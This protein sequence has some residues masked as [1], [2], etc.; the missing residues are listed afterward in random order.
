MKNVDRNIN[1]RIREIA[2]KIFDGNITAMAKA[3]FISRTTIYS[4]IGEKEVSPGYDVLRKLVEMTTPQINLEWLITGQGEMLFE[5]PTKEYPTAVK[6]IP[7]YAVDFAAGFS[8]L[9]NDQTNVPADMVRLPQF[10][11]ADCLVDVSGKSMEPLIS[12]GDCIAIKRLENWREMYLPGE[13]YAIVTDEY[14][15]IKR[16]RKSE[17]GDG[18]LR[19]VPENPDYDP[20]DIKSE[21]VLAMFTVLGAIKKIF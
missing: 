10:S 8:L 14:R 11:G 19:L 12:P 7:Y 6:E 3:T 17:K 15:T 2:E 18:W 20:Q 4:I 21:S 9:Y 13:V 1:Q 5:Q 16:V